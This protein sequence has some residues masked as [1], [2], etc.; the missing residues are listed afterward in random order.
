MILLTF[1][2]VS[3]SGGWTTPTEAPGLYGDATYY[4]PGLM[5][6][7]ARNR[8]VRLEGYVGGV[9][10]NRVGDLGREVWIFW[11]GSPGE[12]LGPYLVVD[13]AARRD[14]ARRLE[15]G[16]VVEVSHQEA[17]R[18]GMWLIGPRRVIVIFVDPDWSPRAPVPG[19]SVVQ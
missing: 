14:Y 4:N 6:I 13:C 9:A 18:Q 12:Y 7:A 8:G 11:P 2:I 3:N 17:R 16:R 10:L 19:Q 5:E 15:L 1:L